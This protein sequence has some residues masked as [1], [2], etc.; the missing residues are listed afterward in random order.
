MKWNNGLPAVLAGTAIASA[1]VVTLPQATWAL[2]GKEINKVAREVT[3]LFVGTKGQHGSGAIIAK[4]GNTYSILTA[5]HVVALKDNYKIV[6]ADKQAHA[7]DYKK[8][9]RVP[10]VD[11][12]VVEFTSDKDYE[13]AGLRKS[14]TT[15]EG[16]DVFVSGWPEP[17]NTKQLIRQFT[18]GRISGYL[19]S[20]IDGYQMIYTNVTRRGMSGGPVFDAGGRIVG[21]HG[22]GDYEDP[23]K[24]VSREGL[25]PE[26]AVSIASLIKPGFNYAVPID[27][28]LM[29]APAAGIY[30][31]LDVATDESPELGAQQYAYEPSDED[32]IDDLDKAL[33]TLRLVNEGID[34]LRRLPGF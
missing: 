4:N 9:K 11:L 23:G 21:I 10:G 19:E 7:I 13:T 31:P 6:T 17:G 32:K 29:G 14:S 33:K 16:Q 24:L 18:S 1:L 25:S 2:T 30:L 27:T 8:I 28:F 26:A 22:M 5:Y 3:V 34:T 12:A 15:S 20:P